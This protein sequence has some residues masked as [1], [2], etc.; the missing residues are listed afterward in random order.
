M[1]KTSYILIMTL[2]LL[3]VSTYFV[4][5]SNVQDKNIDDIFIEDADCN[6][7]GPKAFKGNQEQD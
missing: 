7:S 3:F 5:T 1:L 2:V 6:C 4:F